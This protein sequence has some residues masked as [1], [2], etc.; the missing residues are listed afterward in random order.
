MRC[1]WLRPEVWRGG[2]LGYGKISLSVRWDR[3]A[4]HSCR[5]LFL[6]YVEALTLLSGKIPVAANLLWMLAEVALSLIG[7]K[8]RTGMLCIVMVLPGF[9]SIQLSQATLNKRMIHPKIAL[10]NDCNLWVVWGS[11]VTN[12][13]PFSRLCSN[14]VKDKWDPWISSAELSFVVLANF[15]KCCK[16]FTNCSPFIHLEGFYASSELIGA[17]TRKT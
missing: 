8:L 10:S 12:I 9:K 17:A 7:Y 15:W 11:S 1:L 13:M 2:P 4:R 14:A 5:R 16:N 6:S 3:Q